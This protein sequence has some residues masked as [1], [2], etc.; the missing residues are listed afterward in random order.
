MIYYSAMSTQGNQS[1]SG[2]GLSHQTQ[3]QETAMVTSVSDTQAVSNASVTTVKATSG[4]STIMSQPLESTGGTQTEGTSTHLMQQ[5]MA[6][7]W[8]PYVLPPDYFTGQAQY[9]LSP[10]VQ[11]WQGWYQPRYVLPPVLSQEVP[12]QPHIL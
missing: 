5:A 2:P 1:A 3:D 11:G 4:P 7:Q 12:Q 6:S 9:M 8:Q 10:V